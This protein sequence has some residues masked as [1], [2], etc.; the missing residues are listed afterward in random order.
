MCQNRGRHTRTKTA[1]ALLLPLPS[2]AAADGG[3]AS[4][5]CHQHF[6]PKLHEP[7]TLREAHLLENS[8]E[9]GEHLH[10]K[11]P[12]QQV[13]IQNSKLAPSHQALRCGFLPPPFATSTAAACDIFSKKKTQ[14]QLSSTM[15]PHLLHPPRQSTPLLLLEASAP[16]VRRHL[17]LLKRVVHFK[18]TLFLCLQLSRQP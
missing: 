17:P 7:Q 3:I 4:K 10:K 8:G 1:C 13:K 9:E 11:T 18:N 15:Q 14:R 12:K 16:F 2:T 6:V 5:T